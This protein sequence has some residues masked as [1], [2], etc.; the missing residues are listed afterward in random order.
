MIFYQNIEDILI[1]SYLPEDSQELIKYLNVSDSRPR[2]RKF[3][4][5]FRP[6]CIIGTPSFCGIIMPKQVLQEA[7]IEVPGK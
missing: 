1:V 3:A 5:L 2:V 6:S 4:R 7:Q